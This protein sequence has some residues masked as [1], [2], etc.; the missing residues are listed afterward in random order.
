M[1]SDSYNRVEIDTTQ[2]KGR[3]R[4]LYDTLQNSLSQTVETVTRQSRFDIS[5]GNVDQ[6]DAPDDLDELV[7][8]AKSVGFVWKSYQVFANE[9]WEPGYRLQG[10][11][12]TK[13]YFMGDSE[14]I[15]SAPPP[16]TPEGG[17]LH[18]AGVFAGEKMQDFF[19]IGKQATF[20]RR[21]RGTVLIELLKQD[22]ESS[23]SEISGFAFIRPETISAEVQPNTNILIDPD[24]TDRAGV[25][26]TKRG[27]AAAYIQFDDNS[28]LGRR[29]RFTD[30]EEI[31]LSQNDVHKQVLNPGIGDDATGEQG[32]F[33]TPGIEPISESVTEYRNIMRDQATAIKTKGHG[34]YFIEHGRDVLDLGDRRE[35]VE[36]DDDSMSDFESELKDL[37][38]GG[39]ITHDGSVEPSRLTGD[40][41]DLE[42]TLEHYVDDIFSGL[43]VPKFKVG[44]E[45]NINR[46]V[47]DEQTTEHERLIKAEREYQERQWTK[48]LKRIAERKGLPTEGLQL[49]I[50]PEP[51]DSPVMS[52]TTE[53]IERLATYAQALNSLAGPQG[54]PLTLVDRETILTD[55]A[56]LPEGADMG[57]ELAQ[58]MQR[59]PEVDAEDEALFAEMM[60][61][62]TLAN[63]YSEGDIVNTPDGDGVVVAVW[64]DSWEDVE[65]SE[66]SPAYT[67]ALVD[68]GFDH[69]QASDLEATEFD[70]PDDVEPVEEAKAANDVMSATMSDAEL[71]T[72][73]WTMPDSWRES[74]KPARLILLDAWASMGGQF[75]CGGGCCMGELK[76]E[77]LCAAMKDEVLGTEEWRGWGPD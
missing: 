65:A 71:D 50:E 9:V 64:T 43:P 39:Y 4:Q 12:V 3:V 2:D 46:D 25:E 77:R 44:F 19:D 36:W 45:D 17:F 38:P 21:L 7:D 30:R 22:P 73:D 62:D 53:E 16:E 57:E 55:V 54:G 28:I 27:E 67:V 60:E 13:A 37:G 35:V 15:D 68:G 49:L 26:V 61:M 47:T 75:D 1:S 10:P 11:E 14:E 6:I 41:P 42:S 5:G 56:Q 8:L 58:E 59:T 69:Y 74:T 52:M 18:N 70:T 40:V 66:D 48:V 51:E 31:P 72:L 34:I 24:D 23:E 29:G 20:Q 76:S 33:G 63:R 32:I